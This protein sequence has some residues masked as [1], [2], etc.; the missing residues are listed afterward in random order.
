MSEC[1]DGYQT[2]GLAFNDCLRICNCGELEQILGRND[3]NEKRGLGSKVGKQLP[4][5]PV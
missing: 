5:L 3:I 2:I 4:L 1:R